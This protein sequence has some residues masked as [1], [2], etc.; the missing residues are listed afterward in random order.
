MLNSPE[1]LSTENATWKTCFCLSFWNA[2][3][4]GGHSF[5]FGC[6]SRVNSQSSTGH[7]SFV[8]VPKGLTE[9]S[10]PMADT[11]QIAQ[12]FQVIQARSVTGCDT[13][14]STWMV[15]TSNRQRV[16]W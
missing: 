10:F 2:P 13:G 1:K 15:F 16:K 14:Y 8:N 12:L 11:L 3:F 4:S 7:L 5:I 6:F 9:G